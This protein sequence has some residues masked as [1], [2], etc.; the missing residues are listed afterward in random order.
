MSQENAWAGQGSVVLDIGGDVGAVVVEMPASLTGFEVEARL[1]GGAEERPAHPPHVAV[2]NRQ[3]G[4]GM[5]PSLVFPSL[6]AG[7]Y[8]LVRKGGSDGDGEMSVEVA[9]GEVTMAQWPVVTPADDASAP[10]AVPAGD[11]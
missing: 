6:T 1:E 8:R 3:V 5:V 4:A 10:S 11:G 7:R 9:A 2:V